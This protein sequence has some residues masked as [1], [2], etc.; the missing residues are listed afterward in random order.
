MTAGLYGYNS[1]MDEKPWRQFF[2]FNLRSLFLW[3]AIV[4][5]GCIVVPFIR[6]ILSLSS[7][8]KSILLDVTFAFGCVLT[9]FVAWAVYVR[10]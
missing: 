8:S 9:I 5:I 4:A 3:T 2:Q 10:R 1:A 6:S 7:Y